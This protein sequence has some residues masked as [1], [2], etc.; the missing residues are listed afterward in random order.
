MSGRGFCPDCTTAFAEASPTFRCSSCP[1]AGDL[2][3]LIGRHEP[4]RLVRAAAL[5]TYLGQGL[6]RELRAAVQAGRLTVVSETRGRSDSCSP[7][8]STRWR[9]YVKLP[10]QS[11]SGRCRNRSC[12][13]IQLLDA[14]VDVTRGVM[15]ERMGWGF[16][17]IIDQIDRRWSPRGTGRVTAG[18]GRAPFLL[19]GVSGRVVTIGGYE[20]DSGAAAVSGDGPLPR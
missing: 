16:R 17:Q 8:M 2:H 15:S 20:R 3:E 7:Q 4:G 14:K 12:G 5:E 19:W 13:D 10:C 6:E 9:R 11:H 1:P 18:Q